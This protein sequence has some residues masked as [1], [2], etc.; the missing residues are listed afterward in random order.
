M[1]MSN[2][3]AKSR[4][5]G[6]FEQRSCYARPDPPFRSGIDDRAE[7]SPRTRLV[8][9]TIRRSVMRRPTRFIVTST[10]ILAGCSVFTGCTE[11]SGV[12]GS[13][14]NWVNQQLGHSN[15]PTAQP[16]RQQAAPEPVDTIKA[17][18]GGELPSA[19]ISQYTRSVLGKVQKANSSTRTVHIHLLN[20]TEVNHF[21][22]PTTDKAIHVFL[23]RGLLERLDNE[24][25]LS[26]VLSLEMAHADLGHLDKRINEARTKAI[27]NAAIGSGIMA[28]GTRRITTG[29]A[30]AF[31]LALTQAFQ[32][33]DTGTYGAKFTEQEEMNA[34]RA[35][36][37]YM[38][39][40]DYFPNQFYL[41]LDTVLKGQQD[42]RVK[43][44][45]VYT[46]SLSYERAGQVKEMIDRDYKEP[47]ESWAVLG[48]DYQEKV[49]DVLPQ[50]AAHNI[51]G[52]VQRAS[53]PSRNPRDT[54]NSEYP[55]QP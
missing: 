40:A 37:R 15:T 53:Y 20:S 2:P 32:I 12:L 21:S 11:N 3:G 27:T 19:D 7:K 10:A 45:I 5:A 14:P 46:H 52:S 38:D 23:T 42:A 6:R 48:K 34:T 41:Y 24:A 39:K 36:L 51:P 35:A 28:G 8:L 1:I 4:I 50:T 25:Q 47:K 29:D 17:R 30:M 49:K 54:R 33:S 18:Y 13:I 26:A 55:Q 31:S 44:N 43:D 22:L 9:A 16:A